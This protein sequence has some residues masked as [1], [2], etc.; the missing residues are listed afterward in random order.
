MGAVLEDVGVVFGVGHSVGWQ[1][2][3]VITV[4]LTHVPLPVQDITESKV[5]PRI[6]HSWRVW[7]NS[8][9]SQSICCL[10]NALVLIL[11]RQPAQ[12]HLTGGILPENVL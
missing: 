10:H 1:Q 6:H 2:L 9:S 3:S 4:T 8:V 11:A 12:E 5:Y 7:K